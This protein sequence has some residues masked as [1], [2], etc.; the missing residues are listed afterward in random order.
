[1]WAASLQIC[2]SVNF[3]PRSI[4][5]RAPTRK[6]ALSINDSSA[7][8]PA[9]SQPGVHCIASPRFPAWTNNKMACLSKP[10]N[11][12]PL[13]AGAAAPDFARETAQGNL[14]RNQHSL[15]KSQFLLEQRSL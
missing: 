13:A 3:H 14:D 1:M 6:Y 2:A 5:S 4:A 12:Q 8:L 11:A 15:I 9:L 10:G 7:L